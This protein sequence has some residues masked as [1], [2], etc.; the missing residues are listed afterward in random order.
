MKKESL[1][2]AEYVLTII[3]EASFLEAGIRGENCR[4]LSFPRPEARDSLAKTIEEKFS[5]TDNQLIKAGDC[6]GTVTI[7]E[8]E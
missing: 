7:T 1:E 5:I 2:L 4:G 3:E 8:S 6:S